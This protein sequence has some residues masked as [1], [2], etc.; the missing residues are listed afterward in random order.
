M[1]MDMAMLVESQVTVI[2]CHV[3]AHRV[4]SNCYNIATWQMYVVVTALHCN[5]CTT[6]RCD[7]S[8]LLPLNHPES[9]ATAHRVF[10][11]NSKWWIIATLWSCLQGEML[12]R[13]EYQCE[14]AV[15]YVETARQDTKKA[16]KYQSGA[17]KVWVPSSC[18]TLNA[19]MQQRSLFALA[20]CMVDC[21]VHVCAHI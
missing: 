15:D 21:D 1:F 6:F 3:H 19:C 20:H 13:I 4:P 18:P 12:D 7:Y 17:R 14:Q 9:I 10:C 11:V 5:Y 2:A 16:A 8:S